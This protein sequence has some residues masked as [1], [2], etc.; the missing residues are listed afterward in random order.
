MTDSTARSAGK[1]IAL[2]AAIMAASNLLSRLLG[3][4]RV[5]VLARMAGTSGSVDAYSFSFFLPDLL[6]HVLAGSALS[7]TFIPLFQ[8]YLAENDRDGAWRFFSNVMCTGTI[9]FVLCIG[10]AE[11][12]TDKIL[13]I[14]G[15]NIHDPA[16]PAKFALTVKLTRIILPA[17]LFFF[18]GALLNGVQYAHKRFFFP[19]LAPLL[20]NLGI[21]AGGVGLYATHGVEGFSWGVLA[22]AFAGNVLMQIP[23]ARLAGMRFRFHCSLRDPRLIHYALT[24]LPFIIGLSMQ[25]AHEGLFR[26]FGSYIPQGDGALASLDYSFK[27]MAVL[28]GVFGQAIAAGSYPF[29]SQLTVEG[30]LEEAARLLKNLLIRSGSLL[31]PFAGV[32]ITISGPL[33]AFLLQRGEF[34]AQSTQHTAALLSIY[35]AGAY[36]FA[37]TLIASRAYYAMGKTIMPLA[38]LSAAVL[39]MLP[40]F[41]FLTSILGARGVATASSITMFVQFVCIYGAWSGKYGRGAFGQAARDMGCIVLATAAGMILSNALHGALA[42]LAHTMPSVFIRGAFLSASAGI[43]GLALSF[44]LL[45]LFGVQ[46]VRTLFA[47]VT[48]RLR[49]SRKTSR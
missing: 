43:P 19:A 34:D 47:A 5:V 46:D 13:L 21:I 36:F 16:D 8:K 42:P 6:N 25:F 1:A 12:F 10:L 14:S 33:V 30:K 48:S 37:G 22:G 7:I 9:L 27:I 3:L 31:L 39:L 17:Q 23:G 2:A 35:L 49:S 28:V 11:L 45:Q 15:K 26:F 40:V 4:L 41:M 20:Y 24:T 32:G 18:W 38:I 44:A 29:L